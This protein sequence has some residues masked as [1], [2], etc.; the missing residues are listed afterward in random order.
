[1]QSPVN[2]ASN[3]AISEP[4]PSVHASGREPLISIAPSLAMVVAEETPTP[5][6]QLLPG[7]EGNEINVD[8]SSDLVRVGASLGPIGNPTNRRSKRN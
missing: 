4:T 1:M 8:K 3:V 6:N 7:E 2:V 5:V